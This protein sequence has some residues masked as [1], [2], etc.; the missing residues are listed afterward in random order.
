MSDKELSRLEVLR[1]LDHR[2]LTAAAASELLGLG[3]RQTLRLL[4]AYRTIGVYGL[5][6][7]Q[8]GRPSNRRKPEDVRTEAL[9]IIGERYADFGPTL[10]AE[11]LR[12]L[13]GI[14]LGRETV[15]GWMAEAGI[16][17]TRKKRC[18]RV[19]QPRY[20]RD[21]VGELIQ[22]DGSEHRWFEGRGPKCTLLVFVDDATSRLMQ[23]SF[24]PSE[25]TLSYF[26]ATRAYLEA[27][28]K[29]V[30]LYSDKH[31][32]FRVNR[33][34]AAEGDG[35]TQFGR[36][37]HGLNIDLICAN[38][39]QAKGRVERA[40]KT[41]QDRFVKELRLAGIDAM[42]NGNAFAERFMADYNARFAKAP[43]SLKDL[44]RPLSVRDNLTEAFT[45]RETRL[46]SKALTI[47]Y[48]RMLYI[49]QPTPSAL[50]AAGK[51]IEVIEYPD[52]PV[53][54]RH[55]GAD[56]PYRTFDKERRVDQAAIVE[57]KRLGPLLAII[58]EE[59]L[60][61]DAQA[62]PRRSIRPAKRILAG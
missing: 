20:R 47:Q 25:S 60:R 49:L 10:A 16:W 2:R 13:H 39:S 26:T 27:Y 51:Y 28:G 14:C 35:L 9:A 57:N 62:K 3:R 22:V 50:T 42:E 40:N 19:Y 15:R 53:V 4:K 18:G 38:S 30:A 45:W 1:D 29:P 61:R 54:L 59:Q 36:A 48:D 46:V 24:A 17:A 43:A 6:S 34:D 58:R 32:V 8:R 52:G 21:C 5:I 23:L 11:K 31:G 56:L 37:L 55:D 12:E 7:K 41:L 33:P 44:H